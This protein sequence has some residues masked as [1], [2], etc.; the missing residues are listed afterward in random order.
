VDGL[1]ALL[2]GRKTSVPTDRLTAIHSQ[3]NAQVKYL[4]LKALLLVEIS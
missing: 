4:K 1:L 3:K 2:M